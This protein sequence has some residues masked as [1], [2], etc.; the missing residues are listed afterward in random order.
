VKLGIRPAF[1]GLALT[2]FC[3]RFAVAGLKSLLTL[4][5]VNHVLAADENAVFGLA[6]VRSFL[7]SLFG[8]LSEVGL[9]SQIYGLSNALLYLSVPLC[10]LLGDVV[11]GRR[12]AVQTGSVLM[13]AGLL[14]AASTWLALPGLFVFA[15]GA[16]GVKGNLAAQVGEMF[17]DDQ[18]RRS[19]YAFYLAFLNAGVV[20]GPLV[21]GA[22]AATS[23]WPLGLLAASAGVIVGL[24]IYSRVS[25]D[26]QMRAGRPAQVRNA[27]STIEMRSSRAVPLLIVAILAIFLCFAAYE[28]LSNLVLVWASQHVTL[29]F[30][31]LAM[32]AGWIVS[33]DGLVTILLIAATEW[34]FRAARHRH[35]WEI[36]EIARII[37]GCACCAI[38]YVVLAWAATKSSNA[39]VSIVWILAYVVLVDL[40]IVLVWPAGLSLISAHAPPTLVGLLVGIFYLH[41]FFANLWVGTAGAFYDRMELPLFWLMHAG[42]AASG[43]VLLLFTG[44]RLSKFARTSHATT[45]SA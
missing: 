13:V 37:A 18:E 16:G 44:G 34:G 35:G 9:A 17:R 36:G 32:P 10:G 22:V 11:I 42:I 31:G 8:P 43:C 38:G 27:Q 23:G 33:L 21:C 26:P 45:T 6:M 20:V 24:A 7:E 30:A 40:G 25:R 41:G 39:S 19:A 1:L 2:E 5:L 15:V 28:Q 3:E 4:A 29:S 14:M 12:V